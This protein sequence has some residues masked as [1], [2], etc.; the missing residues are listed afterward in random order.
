MSIKQRM[1]KKLFGVGDASRLSECIDAG[2]AQVAKMGRISPDEIRA[3]FDGNLAM[4]GFSSEEITKL[5]T[6]DKEVE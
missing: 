1:V 6:V 4:M 5:H 2:I 3:Q